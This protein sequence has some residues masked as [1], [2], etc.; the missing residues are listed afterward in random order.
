MC[1]CVCVPV[2]MCATVCVYVCVGMHVRTFQHTYTHTQWHICT[3]ENTHVCACMQNGAQRQN[4]A[5]KVAGK[6][7]MVTYK[8]HL[9][10][11]QK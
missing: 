1:V 6:F 3:Q 4:V 8:T 5:A 11:H 9:H 10:S 2:Y 7:L